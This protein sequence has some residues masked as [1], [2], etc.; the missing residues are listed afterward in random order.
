MSVE[1]NNYTILYFLDYGKRFGG[2][3]NTLIQQAILM[4]QAGYSTVLFFSDY[5]GTQM[6]DEYKEICERLGIEYERATYQISSQTEDIDLVC[7]NENYET[8]RDKIIAYKPDLL[9]SVQLNP[10]IELISRECRIPHIMN[11]YQML[12]EFFSICYMNVFPHYHICDSWIYA[13]MWQQYL[14]TDSTCIRTAVNIKTSKKKETLKPFLR[15]ICVGTFCK[16]KN[17]LT[18]IKA[19]HRALQSGIQGKLTLCGYVEGDYGS[20]CAQ[21]IEKNGLQYAIVMNGFC[22]DMNQEYLQHDILIC[23]ST[24]ESYP[25][26]IS[27]AM[28]N[29]LVVISTPVAGV[30][31]VIVDRENGYLAEDYSEDALCEKIMQVR[32][33]IKSGRI[34]EVIAKT[35]ETFWENHSPKSVTKQLIQYYQHVKEDYNCGSDIECGRELINIATIRNSFS[36]LLEKFYQNQESFREPDKVALK[37]WYLYHIQEALREAVVRNCVFFIWGTSRY[38]VVVKQ[39]VETFIPKVRIAGF[40]DSYRTGEFQGYKIY[41]PGEIIQR[42]NTVIFLA[43][44]NG[45]EEMVEQLK[46]RNLVFN[47]DYFIFSVRRW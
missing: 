19:F 36:F 22:S 1:T 33:D 5:L 40:L 39:M 10:C 41:Q 13:R 11:I 43:A 17:Q 16:R 45:Q 25:N 7:L 30:P 12:P 28:A 27:E 15:C 34:E 21:Y 38:G 32:V 24:R 18:V 46:E 44:V 26:V 35:E 42:E 4:K 37:L 14:H 23:G 2:A 6:H 31:E 9:H 20:K 47:R 3:A 29:G 8:L